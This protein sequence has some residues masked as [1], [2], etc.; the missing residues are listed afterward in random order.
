MQQ[1]LS[2]RRRCLCGRVS[3]P[4]E[5]ESSYPAR[6]VAVATRLPAAARLGCLCGCASETVVLLGIGRR[7]PRYPVGN[8]V[9]VPRQS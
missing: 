1:P 4:V 3:A 8:P 6:T 2:L 5:A 9:T 7:R